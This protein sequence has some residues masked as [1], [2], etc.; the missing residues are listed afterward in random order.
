MGGFTSHTSTPSMFRTLPS[1]TAGSAARTPASDANV[2]YQS[3]MCTSFAPVEPE[4]G[5]IRKREKKNGVGWEGWREVSG[6]GVDTA[7][8]PVA[9][10]FTPN[11]SFQFRGAFHVKLPYVTLPYVTLPYVTLSYDSTTIT[12]SRPLCRIERSC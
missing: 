9:K 6:R 2:A 1:M 8:T 11:G 3:E 7:L 5:M 12:K 10:W 4:R